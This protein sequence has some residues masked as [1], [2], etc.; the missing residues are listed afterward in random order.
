MASKQSTVDY[1][2]D[3]LS[4]AGEVSAKKMFG[5]YGVFLLGRM[6]ALICDEHLYFKPTEAGRQLFPVVHEESP[7]PGAKACFLVAEEDWDNADLMSA[8]ALATAKE[9]PIP[10]QKSKKAH[11]PT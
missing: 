3:Q 5:G 4:G 8:I 6:I 2:L 7:Y 9:L 11:S 1:L 10:K